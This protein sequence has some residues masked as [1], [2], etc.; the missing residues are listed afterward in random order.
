MLISIHNKKGNSI[1][2]IQQ[3]RKNKNSNEKRKF[4]NSRKNKNNKREK[5]LKELNK[6]S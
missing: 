1:K 5:D 4:N 2:P 6:I 3:R